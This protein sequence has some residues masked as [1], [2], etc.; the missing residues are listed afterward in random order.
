MG[1]YKYLLIFLL[2]VQTLKAE[3]TAEE[4]FTNIYENKIWGKK[5]NFGTSGPGSEKNVTEIY[6]K[7]LQKFIKK[8]HIQSVVDVGCGDWEFSQYIDWK[9]IHYMGFDVVLPVIE[10]NIKKFQTEKIQFFHAN[11][12][13]TD[14]PEADLLICKEVLQH[15]PN[16]DVKKFLPQ[17]KKYRYCLITND[18]DPKTK[19]AK[20]GDIVRGPEKRFLDLTKAPFSLKGRKVLFYQAFGDTKQ[21]LLIKRKVKKEVKDKI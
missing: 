19:S 10:R 5:N 4:V 21:V 9:D 13:E 8:H 20:N 14:L 6:R 15:L 17:L 18:V 3:N 11:A 7:Y 16:K 12:I 2:A 1:F